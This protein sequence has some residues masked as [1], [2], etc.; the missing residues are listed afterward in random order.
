MADRDTL[1]RCCTRKGTVSSNLTDSAKFMQCRQTLS[2]VESG[3]HAGC[4]AWFCESICGFESRPPTLHHLFRDGKAYWIKHSDC[5]SDPSGR[6]SSPHR[7]TNL[8][9]YSVVRSITPVWGTGNRRFESGYPDHLMPSKPTGSVESI[10][11][12]GALP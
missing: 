4:E 7:P 6:G 12:D 5:K 2:V 11:D 8:T 9:G 3:I 10:T 1:E